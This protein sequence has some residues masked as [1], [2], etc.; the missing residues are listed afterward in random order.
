MR[1]E[2]NVNMCYEERYG[3]SSQQVRTFIEDQL[4]HCLA[5]VLEVKNVYM[6]D[7]NM[8]DQSGGNDIFIERFD[9]HSGKCKDIVIESY[10][11]ISTD[12]KYII[13]NLIK[14]IEE[15]CQ[16]KVAFPF[17]SA[18]GDRSIIYSIS[19]AVTG[20]NRDN[21]LYPLIELFKDFSCQTYEGDNICIAIACSDEKNCG[22]KVRICEIEDKDYLKVMTS[23]HDT[24]LVCNRDGFILR[25]EIVSAHKGE[26]S[27]NIYAPLCFAPLAS[28]SIGKD[29]VICLN[30]LGEILIFKEGKLHV[31]YRRGKWCF[32]KH[33]ECIKQMTAG[34]AELE[35]LCRSIYLTML[36][37][38][39]SRSGGGI[40]LLSK[41]ALDSVSL[42]SRDDDLTIIDNE[43]EKDQSDSPKRKGLLKKS[44]IRTMFGGRTFAE[45]PRKL[46]QEL[47]AIDGS[48]IV[49]ESGEVLCVGAILAVDGGSPDGGGRTAAAQTLAQHGLGIK[50]SNDGKITAWRGI[51]KEDRT[52]LFSV[53]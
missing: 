41:D 38:S 36:D 9:Y 34:D 15:A 30:R 2:D 45:A 14:D 20:N 29:F 28:S 52:P 5:S 26:E 4:Y 16:K 11:S 44:F 21:N 47:V 19:L 22:D 17:L 25:H 40:G 42:I 33:D 50:V 12:Q 37:V 3:K 1:Y 46:R 51:T 24:L 13:K 18:I 48:T 49:L 35:P 39:F 32:F 8:S 10:E 27:D 7:T 43:I 23:G 6:C 53:G 31:A